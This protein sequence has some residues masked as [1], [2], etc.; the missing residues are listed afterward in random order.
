[1]LKWIKSKF[2]QYKDTVKQNTE[3][4]NL[5][6]AKKHALLALAYW[7]DCE[8]KSDVHFQIENTSI[9]VRLGK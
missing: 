5:Y 9:Y 7:K 3:T 2:T 6:K 4:I 1:M 8:E